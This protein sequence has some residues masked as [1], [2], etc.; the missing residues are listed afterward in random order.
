[1][2][3]GDGFLLFYKWM[4][5]ICISALL[6]W[7]ILNYGLW[8]YRSR[9]EH[10]A[11]EQRK[12]QT[13]NLSMEYSSVLRNNSLLYRREVWMCS[14]RE[15]DSNSFS[16]SFFCLDY[17]DSI[18]SM[19]CSEEWSKVLAMHW[20]SELWKGQS[21]WRFARS[22][23]RYLVNFVSARCR[24]T[25]KFGECLANILCEK[26]VKY[27][28]KSSISFISFN[29]CDYCAKKSDLTLQKALKP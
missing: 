15:G 12:S 17:L 11:K 22:F 21:S 18:C 25:E 26:P 23:P 5:H 19:D 27:D 28:L 20:W 3:S 2:Q 10:V 6:K 9:T 14:H 1:M 4:P 8:G 7:G 13:T 24:H 29:R 16:V